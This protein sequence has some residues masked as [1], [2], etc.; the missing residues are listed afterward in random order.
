MTKLIELRFKKAFSLIEIAI[1]VLVIGL[2]VAGIAQASRLVAKA[3]LSTAKSATKNSPVAQIDDLQVWFE[4][5]L[6]ESFNPVERVNDGQLSAWFD[7]SETRGTRIKATQDNVANRPRYVEKGLNNLPTVKFNRSESAF[8]SILPGGFGIS[9]DSPYTIFSI[10]KNGPAG[11]CGAVFSSGTTSVLLFRYACGGPLDTVLLQQS[12]GQ[13]ATGDSVNTGISTFRLHT[14]AYDNNPANRTLK[15]G[16]N[17]SD[18][19]FAAT[20]TVMPSASTTNSTPAYIGNSTLTSP[21]TLIDGE[22]AEFIVFARALKDDERREVEAY[23][24]KKWKLK[25][26]N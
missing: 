8:F 12:A 7:I 25:K 26:Y 21:I 11:G 3:N 22:V 16:L 9:G 2:I 18:S 14:V 19:I 20:S 5:S 4:T 13:T 23:L 6:D 10:S 15:I 17:G 24:L 1:V